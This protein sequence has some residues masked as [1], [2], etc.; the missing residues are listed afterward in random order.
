[1]CCLLN[2]LSFFLSSPDIRFCPKTSFCALLPNKFTGFFF[3][4]VFLREKLFLPQKKHL[5]GAFGTHDWL[6]DSIS[7]VVFDYCVQLHVC[8]KSMWSIVMVFHFRQLSSFGEYF[9]LRINKHKEKVFRREKRNNF[10]F[11]FP[12]WALFCPFLSFFLLEEFQMFCWLFVNRY[13]AAEFFEDVNLH[14][15]L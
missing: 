14:V 11:F 2:Y 13:I 8:R 12:I 7:E 1:M 3:W 4:K 5:T 15:F 10:P 9:C 6:I